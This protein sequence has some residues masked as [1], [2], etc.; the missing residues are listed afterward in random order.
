V[1]GL[2]AHI[3][4]LSVG[5]AKPRETVLVSGAAGSVGSFV[6]QIARIK[7]CRVVGIAGGARKCRWLTEELG[8]DGAI[9]Y[10]GEDAPDALARLFSGQNLGKQL[11]KIADV[12]SG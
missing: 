8:A 10:K 5:Q 4:L 7:G 2:T 6:V 11:V 3:G 12:T 9:D 1:T